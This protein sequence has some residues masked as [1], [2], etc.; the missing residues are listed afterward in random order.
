MNRHTKKGNRLSVVPGGL[1][2]ARPLTPEQKL[3]R[4][5]RSLY[6]SWKGD[7]GAGPYASRGIANAAHEIN[8]PHRIPARRIAEAE[9]AGVKLELIAQFGTLLTEFARQKRAARIGAVQESKPDPDPSAP[10]LRKV[11]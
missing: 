5:M 7:E 6:A 9:A 3:D 1:Y 2:A 11:A 4:E 8:F 10:A